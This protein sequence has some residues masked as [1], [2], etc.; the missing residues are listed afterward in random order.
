MKTILSVAIFTTLFWTLTC[1]Q[2][3]MKSENEISIDYARS[4]APAANT[5]SADDKTNG[6]FTVEFKTEPATVKANEPA[7]L[8]FR[9]KNAKGETVKDLPTVH[10]KPM[11]LLVVSEDLSEFYHIH[12]EPQPDGTYKVTNAFP[13]GGI[14]RLYADFTPEG[15]PQVVERLSVKVEGKER[16]KVALAPDAKL[17]KTIEN[18][19]VAMKPEAEIVAGR[20]LMLDFEVFDAKTNKPATDLQKYLGEYAHFVIISEDLKQ[21]VHA[22]PMSKEAHKEAQD[23]SKPHTHD[24]KSKNA[25][26][27]PSPSVVSAHTSFPTAGIYKVWAQFQR[28]GR[29]ITVPFTVNVKADS[30]KAEVKAANV[31]AGATKVTVSRNGYDP[32]EI[33]LEIGKP[34]KLAFYRADAENCGGEVVFSKLDITRKLPIGETV[35]IEFTPQESG[36]I[37]FACGMGMYRGKVLVN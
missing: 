13:N 9:V 10:E 32:S 7:A 37:S 1:N 27:A 4:D 22:H 23:E 5:N 24:A 28:G 25:K 16:E 19:R 30:Q 15:S 34:A 2:A 8:V 35:L 20:E 26:N 11:H 14:Y 6:A 3:Q 31:P 33:K 17:E 29:V 36:E 18:L 12:P 21:F